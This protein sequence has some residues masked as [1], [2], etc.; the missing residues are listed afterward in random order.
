LGKNKGEFLKKKKSGRF[1]G[2]P[3][4]PAGFWFSR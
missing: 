3:C 1:F 2:S 4:A